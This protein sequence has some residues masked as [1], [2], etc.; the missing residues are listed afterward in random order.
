MQLKTETKA[1]LNW[2]PDLIIPKLKLKLK[3]KSGLN[4][5]DTGLDRSRRY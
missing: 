2:N 4:E 1:R 5:V 3:L